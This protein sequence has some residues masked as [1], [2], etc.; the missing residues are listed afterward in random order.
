MTRHRNNGGAHPARFVDPARLPGPDAGLLFLRL[1]G[2][3]LLLYVHGLP[4]LMHFS[5]ELQH[6]DDPL[7][8][9]HGVTLVLA[10]FAEIVCPLL[11]AAG[12]LTRLATLPILFLLFVSMALVHP[13][14]DVATGQF[15]WLLVIVFGTIALA[16]PGEYSIDGHQQ[17]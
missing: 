1:A 11:I 17:R 7:H 2:S 10:L 15:A 3:A 4:K 6:I 12:W 16:G 9:G 8:L 13:D 5:A 14:W